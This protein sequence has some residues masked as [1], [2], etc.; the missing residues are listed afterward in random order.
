MTSVN[1]KENWGNLVEPRRHA[2]AV[3]ARLA[4][5]PRRDFAIFGN[6]ITV[7]GQDDA[8]KRLLRLLF[9]RR[10]LRL[11]VRSSRFMPGCEASE[12]SI[13]GLALGKNTRLTSTYAAVAS[14]ATCRR[15]RTGQRSVYD[16]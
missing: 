6:R 3:G 8:A 1:E 2:A 14:I 13:S 11:I 4:D 10:T 7:V 9:S 16:K 12:A 5:N 15:M